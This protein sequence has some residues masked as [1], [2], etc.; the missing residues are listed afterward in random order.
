MEPQDLDYDLHRYYTESDNRR[1]HSRRSYSADE[2]D[3]SRRQDYRRHDYYGEEL[4][5]DDEFEEEF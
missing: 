2:Y 4:D 5:S 3:R 1:H